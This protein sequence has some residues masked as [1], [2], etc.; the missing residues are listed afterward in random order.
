M[1][2]PRRVPIAILVSGRGTNM[3]SLVRA[4]QEG[5]LHADVRLVLSNKADAAGLQRAAEL[6]VPTRVMSHRDYATREAFDEALADALAQQGVE[7]VA[8]AGFMRVLTPAFLN[9]FPRR[10]VNIHPALLPS[11]PGIHAQRQALEYGAKVSGCTVHFVDEGTDTG[12][13]IAQVAVPV[14]DGDDEDA[15]SARILEN[16]N[17]LYPQALDDVL[18]GRLRIEGRRVVRVAEATPC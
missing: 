4:A 13:V 9:R 11:F 10:V 14:L 6:G 7:Y 12:P 8:L 18:C 2:E 3:V 16:E 17:R 1:S 15:L 5:R